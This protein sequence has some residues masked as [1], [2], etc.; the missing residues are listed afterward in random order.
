MIRKLFSSQFQSIASAAMIIGA[1]SLT[2]RLIGVVRDRVLAASFGAGE[3][4]DI[5]Y[6]AFR[7]PDLV[8]QLLVTGALSAG[9]VPLFLSYVTKS[10]KEAHAFSNAILRLVI[11]CVGGIGILGIIF[12]PNFIP[13][14][15]PGFHGDVLLQTI[16]VSRIM[17]L[18]PFF[19][20]ISS[21]LCGIHESY[22][23]F[24]SVA[25]APILYNIGIIIGALFLVPRYGVIG[26]AYGVVFGSVFHM[27]I[28][29]PALF[30]SGYSFLGSASLFGEGT[31]KLF[32]LMI[33]RVLT[34][35]IFQINLLVI[36][37]LTSILASGSLAIF[38]WAFNLQSFPLGIFGVSLA[39]A[40][41]S[42]LSRL[43][44]EGK[45]E[46]FLEQFSQTVKQMCFFLIPITVLFII[47]RAQIVRVVLG[48][49]VFDWNDT[50]LTMNTL[51]VLS[52]GILFQSL[53]FLLSRAFYAL[54]KTMLPFFAALFG[55]G[56]N[57]LA[58]FALSKHY[59]VVGLALATTLSSMVQ[60]GVLWIFF[61]Q[62][63]VGAPS[64]GIQKTVRKIFLAT[65]G[66]AIVT[67]GVKT[68]LGGWLGTNTFFAVFLQ[69][70]IAGIFG[71]IVFGCVGYFL[72]IDELLIFFSSLRKKVLREN[73]PIDFHEEI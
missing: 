50:V 19:F 43:A 8:F 18:S 27:L 69:G 22:R 34:L 39:V 37:A 47:L 32:R 72:H 29:L 48:G 21:V 38:N 46:I 15:V 20:G 62:E 63:F 53:V 17:F 65:L 26:L 49:G 2:S 40:A 71:I 6:A 44:A 64:L 24:F 30:L 23:R 13:W 12:A 57:F 68:L 10:D 16:Q 14:L 54:Q 4:L 52:V 31:K 56:V 73:R 33:P 7:I 67:Q 45:R 66:M 3:T 1:F 59:G 60:L 28:Q 11:L 61:A 25:L 5:Y 55:A 36:T 41:F 58:A 35:G 51:G 42:N 70:S 9:F